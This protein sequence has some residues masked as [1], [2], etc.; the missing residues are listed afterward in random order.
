MHDM[1]S[2][3]P[4]YCPKELHEE[5]DYLKKELSFPHK[6]SVIR[7]GCRLIREIAML[8]G[9]EVYLFSKKDLPRR[10]NE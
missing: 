10:D 1:T 6:I 9:D 3:S 4:L 2:K 5:L 8:Q 7:E